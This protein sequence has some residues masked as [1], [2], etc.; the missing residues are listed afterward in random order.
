MSHDQSAC[1]TNQLL[2]GLS[3]EELAQLKPYMQHY[4]FKKGHQ[5]IKENTNG[6]TVYLIL[7]GGVD[8]IKKNKI[9][10]QVGRYQ[11]VGFMSVVDKEMRSATV[12]ANSDVEVAEM[13]AAKIQSDKPNIYHKLLENHITINQKRLRYV[14]DEYV[15]VLE[16]KI[17]EE[18]NKVAF[19]SNFMTVVMFFWVYSIFIRLNLSFFDKA[20]DTTVSTVLLLLI[21]GTIGI[22]MMKRM[23]YPYEFYGITLK[24][25]R[26]VL[27]QSFI[28]TSLII[29]LGLFVKWLFIHF[30]PEYQH[31]ALFEFPVF[32][33]LGIGLG[34]V[35][36]IVYCVFTLVQEGITRC[37]LQ[38]PLHHILKGKY[39]HVKT[40]ILTTI[41]F[42]TMHMHFIDLTVPL[43][44]LI[45]GLY[46]SIMFALQRSLLGTSLSHMMIGVI[47]AMVIGFPGFH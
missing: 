29:G 45:P 41:V 22:I 3:A 35:V 32:R 42:S 17:I 16:Q 30:I 11:S 26:K 14:N 25:W 20:I 8:V 40:V 43:I 19:A 5:L 9:I 46:W 38:T 12:I 13:N 18:K 1:S 7:K 2:K 44:V 27:A 4:A 15:E 36:A 47:G 34:I 23:P 33:K 24:N 6:H 39:S 37:L 31:I 10:N 28:A 21:I